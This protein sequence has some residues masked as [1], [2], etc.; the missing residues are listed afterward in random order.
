MALAEHDI[1]EVRFV[2][3]DANAH[4]EFASA[5]AELPRD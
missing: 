2:L 4:D 5:L 1:D 3:F